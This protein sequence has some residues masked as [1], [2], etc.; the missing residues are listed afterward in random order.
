MESTFWSNVHVNK[1]LDGKSLQ[2]MLKSVF[3]LNQFAT[4]EVNPVAN[5]SF[6]KLVFSFYFYYYDDDVYLFIY[7]NFLIIINFS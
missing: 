2:A 7:F 1:N 5:K 3:S 4:H 6:R